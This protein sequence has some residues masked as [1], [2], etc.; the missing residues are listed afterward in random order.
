MIVLNLAMVVWENRW[1][2]YGRFICGS[3]GKGLS[4][5][6][7]VVVDERDSPCISIFLIGC[8]S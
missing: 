3:V 7:T 4:M 5:F 2:F 1:F 8:S 6:P